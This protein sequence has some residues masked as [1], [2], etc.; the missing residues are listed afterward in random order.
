MQTCLNRTKQIN[1]HTRIMR[2]IQFRSSF[3]EKKRLIQ[4]IH[5]DSG[6]KLHLKVQPI[7]KNSKCSKNC[8]Y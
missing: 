8:C 5:A 1:D 7:L 6:V 3:K 2:K 4:N